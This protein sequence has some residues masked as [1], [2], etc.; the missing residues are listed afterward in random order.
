MD[1]SL[2]VNRQ[3]TC[4]FSRGRQELIPSYC[5][6]CLDFTHV[7]GTRN[8]RWTGS[9]AP[10][11]TGRSWI[12]TIVA[13]R[14]A[15]F[16]QPTPGF[17]QHEASKS[18]GD[19][20]ETRSWSKWAMELHIPHHSLGRMRRWNCFAHAKLAVSLEGELSL[21]SSSRATLTTFKRENKERVGR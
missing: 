15:N 2:E 10:S 7:W 8:S 4:N 16:A 12:P 9:T 14:N 20:N 18:D 21:V 3:R 19:R 5:D 11:F 6:S 13:A 1:A 17:L